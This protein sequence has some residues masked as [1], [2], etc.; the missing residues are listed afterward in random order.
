MASHGAGLVGTGFT[1][2]EL[3]IA[4]VVLG[5][6]TAIAVPSFSNFVRDSRRAATLNEFVAAL[7]LARSEAVKRGVQ[8]SVCRAVTDTACATGASGWRD[9][10][11]VFVNME[12]AESP[13]VVETADGDVVLRVHRVSD[14]VYTLQ[15]SDLFANFITYRADGTSQSGGSFT[16]CDQRGA[17]KAR[18][19]LISTVGRV[20][21][22]RDVDGDG[23]EEDAG[24]ADL[25]CN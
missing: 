12:N 16:Y 19:V 9:G 21:L 14:P 4:V 20:R 17:R 5:I 2:I 11:L 25:A 13:A 18:A 1:L 7:S 24:N 23:V 6:L 3:L 22:S 15:P 10:W 8:V